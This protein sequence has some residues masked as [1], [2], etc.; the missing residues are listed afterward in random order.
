MYELKKLGE[1]T[2]YIDSPNNVGVYKINENEVYLIDAGSDK[3]NGKKIL[4]ILEANGLKVKGIINTHS[5]ADHI[6]GDKVIEERTN[7][8]V[9]ANGIEKV[10]T[11][12][13]ILEPSFL[14]GACP[15]EELKNK[16]LLAKAPQ[17]VKELK[18]NLPEGLEIINLPGHFFDMVGIKT[19]DNIYF[20]ADCLF[21]K[22]T[23][24]KYH[25]FFIYDVKAFLETLNMLETLQGK[26]YVPSHNELIT[27]LKDLIEINRNKINEICDSILEILKE[28]MTFEKLLKEIFYKYSLTM[29][30]NQYVLVGSTLRSYLAYL[31]DSGKVTFEITNNEM[32][33]KSL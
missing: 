17:K 31:K 16:F 25:I 30:L 23:I 11:E 32:I 14:Y 20:L 19:D 18:N 22:E 10:I 29:N 1:K 27:D 8:E 7:C 33:W 13:P 4:K 3:D 2:Y 28:P 15:F 5:N 12:Y 21:S 26:A 24:E 6:G 9:L